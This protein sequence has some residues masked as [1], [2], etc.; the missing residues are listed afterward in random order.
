MT[1]D[2][3][4]ITQLMQKRLDEYKDALTGGDCISSCGVC[5]DIEIF[6]ELLRGP[7]TYYK[8]NK[9][10]ACEYCPLQGMTNFSQPKKTGCLA[11]DAK[12]ETE[13]SYY[14]DDEM[15]A[16]RYLEIQCACAEYGIE[17]S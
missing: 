15:L 7:H 1:K 2:E 9:A 4:F 11:G 17:V 6:H 14:P 3:R 13:V 12:G 10:R 5:L 8:S 16:E